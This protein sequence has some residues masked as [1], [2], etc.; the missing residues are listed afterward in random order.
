MHTSSPS[1]GN[2]PG[3]ARAARAS[4]TEVVL[5]KASEI[6]PTRV[7]W[8]WTDRVPLGMVTLLVGE[9]GLGKSTLLAG[10]T[11]DV[12]TGR[13][14]GDLL[15][16]PANVLYLTGEDDPDRVIVPRLCAAGADRDR[17]TFMDLRE[18]S[19]EPRWID[20]GCD[21]DHL[22]T[23]VRRSEASLIV[24]D[25]IADFLGGR[26]TN[27]E[28]VMRAILGPLARV[29]RELRVTTIAARHVN[30]QQT[31]DPLRRAMG[32]RA[33]TQIARSVLIFGCDPSDPD[34][35]DGASRVLALGKTN[36]TR[37]QTKSIAYRLEETTIADAD[38]SLMAVGHLVEIGVTATRADEL[39]IGAEERPARRRDEAAEFLRRALADHEFHPSAPIKEDARAAGIA[40]RTLTDATRVLGVESRNRGYPRTTEWR[41]PPVAQLASGA[42]D[43]ADDCATGERAGNQ[44]H[45]HLAASQS[46]SLEPDCVTDRDLA[47]A[48]EEAEIER[49]RKKFP[50]MR[51][52]AA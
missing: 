1:G 38:G 19:G 43:R 23:G 27:R 7:T 51:W 47:S 12:T 35:R 17:V 13:L 5:T 37:S 34:G 32:S 8:L 42:T 11:A 45:L 39:L 15:G 14:P 20:L 41:L 9:E 26:D 22:A 25:P 29:A 3:I 40:P 4:E 33:F 46:R 30:S 52:P 50:D 24:I 16:R 10:M 49:V 44:A 36:Y 6:E 2:E 18:P 21:L 48:S 28:H 31:G